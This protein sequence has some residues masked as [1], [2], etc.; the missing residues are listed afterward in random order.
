MSIPRF[1]VNNPIA[2]NFL[3]MLMLV[4]GAYYA[5]TLPRELFPAFKPTS[6]NVI[7]SYPGSSPADLEKGVLIKIEE[8]IHDLDDLKR[9]TS[10]VSEGMAT[11][12]A[13]F[14]SREKRRDADFHATMNS[15]PRTG[16]RLSLRRGRILQTCRKFAKGA[17]A[18]CPDPAHARRVAFV[19]GRFRAPSSRKIPHGNCETPTRSSERTSTS[20]NA[21]AFSMRDTNAS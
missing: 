11:L 7:V 8:A 12:T 13:E 1:S 16:E 3:M 21:S 18:R 9:I 15:R 20:S 2:A 10:N 5:L 19:R 6:V 14:E 17:R 4:G